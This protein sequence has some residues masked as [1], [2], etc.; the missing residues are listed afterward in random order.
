MLVNRLASLFGGLFVTSY[1]RMDPKVQAEKQRSGSDRTRQI[2]F[3]D[4]A[5]MRQPVDSRR[6]V[7]GC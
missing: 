2:D 6:R 1:S 4:G 3:Q 5:V 7:I